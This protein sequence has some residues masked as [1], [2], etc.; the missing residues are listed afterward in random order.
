MERLQGERS[1]ASGAGRRHDELRLRPRTRWHLRPGADRAADVARLSYR[2]RTDEHGDPRRPDVPL[3][4]RQGPACVLRR[5]RGG[6]EMHRSRSDDLDHAAFARAAPNLP[7]RARVDLA[8]SDDCAHQGRPLGDG[9][10]RQPPR[11]RPEADRADGALRHRSRH[12]S[13]EGCSP[14]RRSLRAGHRTRHFE[15]RPRH[16]GGTALRARVHL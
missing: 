10:S 9:Q 13:D 3:P 5:A 14:P 8:A 7:A 15:T 11:R 2:R 16:G 6:G 4:H 12:R 1:G